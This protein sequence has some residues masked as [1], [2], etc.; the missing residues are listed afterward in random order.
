MLLGLG[1]SFLGA[2]KRISKKNFATFAAYFEIQ[3]R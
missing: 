2:K 3:K 1:G